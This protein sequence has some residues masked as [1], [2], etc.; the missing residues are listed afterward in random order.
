M[1]RY[2]YII[3]RNSP[4]M[5]SKVTINKIKTFVLVV[6]TKNQEIKTIKAS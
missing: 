2:F 4:F 6:V 1:I 5:Y 3:L